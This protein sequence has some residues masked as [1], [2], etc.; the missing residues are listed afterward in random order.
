MRKTSLFFRPQ[1]IPGRSFQE[2]KG[3]K[4]QRKVLRCLANLWGLSLLYLICVINVPIPGLNSGRGFGGF[5]CVM[6]STRIT[7]EQKACSGHPGPLGKFLAVMPG[8]C[9]GH[10]ERRAPA[11]GALDCRVTPGNDKEG[12]PGGRARV[13]QGLPAGG[14]LQ[15][16]PERFFCWRYALC[17]SGSPD[18][19]RDSH[20]LRWRVGPSCMTGRVGVGRRPTRKAP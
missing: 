13:R 5:L 18:P 4:M 1:G 8:A 3:C 20:A 19:D 12:S 6:P 17:R 16:P 9:P 11:T 7:F 14:G 10:P 2:R 15:P